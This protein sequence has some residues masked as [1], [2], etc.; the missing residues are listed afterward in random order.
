MALLRLAL[1][2]HQLHRP[3]ETSRQA[4]SDCSGHLQGDTH[5]DSEVGCSVDGKRPVG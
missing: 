2:L 5:T 3:V 1:R 4:I